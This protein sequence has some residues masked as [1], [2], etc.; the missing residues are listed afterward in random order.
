MCR[1]AAG[2]SFLLLCQ[3]VCQ[4]LPEAP[5]I[6]WSALAQRGRFKDY[7]N[8]KSAVQQPPARGGPGL[9]SGSC[10]SFVKTG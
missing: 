9:E 1:D 10:G 4:E 5:L 7:P 8:Q 6:R 2:R 3:E